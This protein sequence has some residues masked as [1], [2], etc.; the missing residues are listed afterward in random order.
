MEQKKKSDL[1]VLLDYAGNYRGLT[2][3]GLFLSA[4]AMILGMGPYICIWLV[5]RDLVAVAPN[6]Q[7]ASHISQY[8]WLAFWLAVIGILIYF[9]ALMC[10]HLAAFRTA[11]AKWSI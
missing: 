11:S 5:A 7:Q 2:Y 1:T 4:I 6:W 10:T 9:V 3:F 8:G